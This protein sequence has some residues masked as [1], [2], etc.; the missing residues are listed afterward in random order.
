MSQATLRPDSSA[1][2]L[3]ENPRLRQVRSLVQG[4]MRRW[5]LLSLLEGAGAAVSLLLAY[6]LFV[7]WLDDALHLSRIGRIAAAA[8]LSV[9]LLALAVGLIRRR[10]RLRMSEDHVALAIERR[11]AGGMQNR[12]I[13]ALQLARAADAGGDAAAIDISRA[14][15]EENVAGMQQMR[16]EQAAALRPALMRVGIAVG[17]IALAAL[18]YWREPE[19]FTNSAERIFLPLVDIEPIYRTKLTVAPGDVEASGDVELSIEIEGLRPSTLTLVEEADGV[20][21]SSELTVP[22]TGPVRHTLRDVRKSRL[23]AVR[24]G[25]F[26]TPFYRI[27]VPTPSHLSV[28]TAVYKYP[29]YTGLADRRTESAAGDLEGLGGTAVELT[30]DFD[31]P[32]T[33]GALLVERRPADEKDKS[34]PIERIALKCI[35]PARFIGTLTL[36]DQLAYRVET[37]QNARAPFIGK[38]YPIRVLADLEPKLELTGFDGKGDVAIDAV[39]PYRAAATDD[40]GLAD[41]GL[42]MRR[43]S[44]P[45]APVAKD[46]AAT[47]AKEKEADWQSLEAWSGDGKREFHH[48]ADLT[49]LTLAAAEG[50]RVE[51]ALRAKDRD[52][53]RAERWTVGVVYSLNIGGDA[54]A[55]QLLYERIIQ[56]EMELKQA[57]A[58]ERKLMVQTAEWL[59]KL[60]GEGGLKWDDP[61]NIA[62]LHAGVLELTKQQAALRAKGGAIARAM[63]AEA[64]SLQMSVGLLAD[65]EMVR[66]ERI[67]ES[68]PTRDLLQAKRSA[69][70]DA[71]LTEQRVVASLQQMIDAYGTFRYEWELDHLTGFAKML[72]D[73]QT[74]LRETSLVNA[75]RP[76]DK[77]SEPWQASA[78]RR[79]EKLQELTALLAAGFTSLGE[80]LTDSAPEG[81]DT[82][83]A[84]AFA[85]AGEA[86][87]AEDLT[88]A[89]TKSSDELKAGKWNEAAAAQQV[90]ATKLTALYEA[91][92]KAQTEAAQAAI[93]ALEEKAKSD[94]AAQQAIEKLKAG[95]DKQFGLL[96]EK[97]PVKDLIEMRDKLDM[98]NKNG[99]SETIA[100]VTDYKISDA[101]KAGLNRPDTGKRQD[102]DILKLGGTKGGKTPSF[103]GTSDTEANT[104]NAPVQ[105]ELKD[106]VGALL[107]EA[108]EMQKN[109]E[110]SSLNTAFNIN[111]AGEVGKLGGDMNSFAAAATT[112]NKKPPTRNVG[113][114]SRSGR[115]GARAHG[116][117]VGDESVNRR[118]RDQVQEGQERVA[119]QAGLIKETMSDDPQ[120]DTSTGV[121]GKKVQ[122][123][124][125]K[126]S[127]ANVGKWTDDMANRM[128]KPQ[129]KNYIVERQDGRMD[130]RVADMLKDMTA[131]QEQMIERVKAIRK[132][133]KNLYLPTDRLDEILAE[134]QG[135]LDQLKER[136]T[137]ELFRLQNETLDKLRGNLRVFQ[138]AASGFQP[139]LP[140]EQVVRGRVMDDVERTAPPEYAE[141][142]KRYYLRLSRGEGAK[143]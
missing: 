70:A 50:E 7:V 89:L 26:A 113:G 17:L 23:Y 55:L 111:E 90:A 141:A 127:T 71:Q 62:T 98:E 76:R 25:D 107:E 140:R 43:A 88:A 135:Q 118:G 138:Q 21:T 49:L 28:L 99:T 9:G 93:K 142:I 19:R 6:L 92:R 3:G 58:D 15:I 94:V 59:R 35:G 131:D 95:T 29:Q 124:D 77:L 32:C 69:M 8:G 128:G 81:S 60:D 68:I 53:A 30:L 57:L 16:V 66:A 102:F 130:A 47:N 38:S 85:A 51:L 105:E 36:R 115:R 2:L 24:G 33:E 52:P 13:N 34:P 87:G 110:T 80:K 96:P 10:R 5:R 101:T 44:Q 40:W 54:A 61:K 100:K 121:G 22:V 104:V 72:V 37:R 56:T 74:A 20:R 18:L 119:D 136:P 112:G 97:M 73:R 84:D 83:L 120:N 137:A 116:V 143:P 91:L 31:A 14:V 134:L 126:F 27:T 123:D 78:L 114:A 122:S 86:A 64:G 63:P 79:Q 4:N 46:G 133:L 125:T 109:F 106:L 75:K 103:P 45:Q 108:D 41:V 48:A 67:F 12:L 65:T 82:S 1:S 139:S 42:V 132:E 129:Q 117:V 11:T 39:L